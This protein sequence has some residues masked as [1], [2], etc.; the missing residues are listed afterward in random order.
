MGVQKVPTRSHRFLVLCLFQ[1]QFQFQFELSM[2]CAP[3]RVAADEFAAQALA[4][5]ASP[6][7]CPVN[8]VLYMDV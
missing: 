2:L 8:R 3:V 6:S 7:P 4:V 5:V 1:F